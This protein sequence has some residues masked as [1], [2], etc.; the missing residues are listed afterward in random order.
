MK[1][2]FNVQSEALIVDERLKPRPAAQVMPDWK[3]ELAAKVEHEFRQAR[4]A[5]TCPALHD[6]LHLGY[7]IP[8][9]TDMR[10]ERVSVDGT[11][12]PKADPDGPFIRWQTAH[13]AFPLEFHGAEQVK[14]AEPLQPTANLQQLVKPI[15]PWLIETPPGWSILV[16]P[17]SLHE[18]KKQLPLIPLPGV[19]NTDHWHQIHAPCR[20]GTVE[21]VMTLR[22]GT[23]FMHIIPFRRE[24][25]LQPEFKV[26]REQARLANL[27]GT[28]SD[29]SGGYR[30]QQKAFEAKHT[31]E[32][33][34]G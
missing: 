19:V 24:D 6:Y 32:R 16:L 17:L 11:G 13:G 4:S 30:R 8:L 14:G 27:A 12:R 15:C 3:K 21:P 1:I 33:A 20:W 9:W 29:F 10:L 22:A 26:I 31:K 28:L 25:A 5:R 34:D 18:Q 23:P 7:V 2:V